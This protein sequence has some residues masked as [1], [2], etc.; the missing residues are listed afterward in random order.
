[1]IYSGDIK[2]AAQFLADMVQTVGDIEQAGKFDLAQLD[3]A[4]RALIDRLDAGVTELDAQIGGAVAE[5]GGDPQV[6]ATALVAQLA[7]LEQ[8][9]ALVDLRGYSG[10]VLINV[11]QA[12]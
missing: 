11:E 7:D 6:I 3:K 12:G 10:R 4:A 5:A 9:S 8:M 2:T 1:M